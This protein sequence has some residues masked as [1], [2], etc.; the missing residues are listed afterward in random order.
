MS[1]WSYARQTILNPR[2]RACLWKHPLRAGRMIAGAGHNYLLAFGERLRRS[3][4]HECPVCRWHGRRFR[5]YVAPDDVIGDCICPR[6]GSFD[7]QRFLVF[8]MRRV[9]ADKARVPRTLLGLSVSPAMSWLLAH[10]GLGRCFRSDFDRRDPRFMPDVIAD[11][12]RAGFRAEAFDWIICSHVLEHIVEFDLAVDELVRL[13]RPGG[14]A[15]IQVAYHETLATSH[16]IPLDPHDYDAH[17]WRFGAD[18]TA[19][20]AR[21]GWTVTAEHAAILA[22]ALRQ[23]HGIHAVERYWLGQKHR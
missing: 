19:R 13:L 18:V 22:P 9:L 21:P 15:W 16:P 12:R 20:L 14:L 23:R 5:T 11:L 8:G 4:R 7:R 17:A 10:E 1:A 6:C 3:E 2:S